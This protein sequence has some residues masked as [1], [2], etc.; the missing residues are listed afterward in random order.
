MKQ[1]GQVRLIVVPCSRDPALVYLRKVHRHHGRPQGFKLALACLEEATGRVCGVAMLGRPIARGL[2]D[3]YTWEVVRLATDGTPNACSALLGAC[4]RLCRVLRLRVV[5]YTL[6]E[7]G[8]ASLRAAG[9]EHR[10]RTHRTPERTWANRPDREDWVGG[11]KDR[12]GLDF[13]PTDLPKLV[14]E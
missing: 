13:R 10:A 5:T 6:P 14:W 4:A 9:W 2:D 3:G 1:D 7:E 8:G 12:W 11:D